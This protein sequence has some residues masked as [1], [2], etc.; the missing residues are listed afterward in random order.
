MNQLLLAFRYSSTLP[1][2]AMLALSMLLRAVLIATVTYDSDIAHMID[3]APTYEWALLF[4]ANGVLLLWRIM[5]SVP[6]IEL[7]R[8]INVATCG[9]LGGYIVALI[10]HLGD[11]P[12]SDGDT[13]VMLIFAIWVTMRT[14]LTAS[15]RE[16][17]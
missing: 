15:D 13:A 9:V 10:S 12:S 17:A 5:D 4:G 16:S 14:N 2:R 11:L 8:F 1:I 3:I 6:R 7:T